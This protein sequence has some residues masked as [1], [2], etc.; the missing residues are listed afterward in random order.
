MEQQ[1]DQAEQICDLIESYLLTYSFQILAT[2][3]I[4]LLGMW[5]ARKAFDFLEQF[6]VRENSLL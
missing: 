6:M 4:L 2:I 3:I 1:L 5:V